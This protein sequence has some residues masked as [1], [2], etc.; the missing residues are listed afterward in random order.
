MYTTV[1]LPELL[2]CKKVITIHYTTAQNFDCVQGLRAPAY[3]VIDVVTDRQMI[4]QYDAKH[5]SRSNATN[6][7]QLQR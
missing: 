5:A 7:R 6:I 4:G 2:T 1:A 3:D